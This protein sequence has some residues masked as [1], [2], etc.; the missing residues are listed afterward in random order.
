MSDS[1]L[2][3][4][5]STVFG[6]QANSIGIG[7]LLAI[8]SIKPQYWGIFAIIMV[9]DIVAAMVLIFLFH[10][11]GFLTKTEEDGHAQ[12]TLKEASEGLVEPT[13]FTETTEVISP[14][15]GQVKLLSQATDPVFSSGVMG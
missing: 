3:G 8:L 10:K 1:A 13:V 15:A 6:V 2:S 4:L 14:L 5:L 11:T 12:E 7:G 9:V